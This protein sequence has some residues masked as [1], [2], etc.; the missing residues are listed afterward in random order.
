MK[1]KKIALGRDSRETV[2]ERISNDQAFAS[3]LLEET[4]SVYFGGEAAIAR[5]V[6]RDLVN[7]TIGFEKLSAQVNIPSKSLHRMLSARGNPS[8]NNLS[9]IICALSNTLKVKI[10]TKVVPANKKRKASA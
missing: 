8:M 7:G 3:S 1:G 10:E 9:A 6:L 5:L 2:I 4:I